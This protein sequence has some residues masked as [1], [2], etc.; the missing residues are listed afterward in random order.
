M[1]ALIGYKDKHASWLHCHDRVQKCDGNMG[2]SENL[3]RGPPISLKG[4]SLR[5]QAE[6]ATQASSMLLEFP[7]LPLNRSLR[8]LGVPI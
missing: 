1:F 7:A 2:T 4:G 5:L 6:T 3:L 8:F